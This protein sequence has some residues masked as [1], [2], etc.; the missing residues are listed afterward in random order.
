MTALTL[1]VGR[2]PRETTCERCGRATQSSTGFVYADGDAHA[3]YHA[4]LHDHIDQ[5]DMDLAIGIGTW[6]G[7]DA[8]A[9]VSAFLTVWAENDQIRFGFVDPDESTWAKA[10]LLRN[11]LSGSAARESDERHELLRIA[12]LVVEQDVAV[13]HHLRHVTSADAE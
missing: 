9:T 1:E 4:A 5:S 8:V 6:E 12:E 11:Q 10:S 2:P 3:I 7:D 13:N